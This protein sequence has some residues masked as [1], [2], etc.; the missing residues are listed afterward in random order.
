[1]ESF[2]WDPEKRWANLRKH[3]LDFADVT[4][5]F[6]TERYDYLSEQRGEESKAP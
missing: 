4:A 2:E 5:I 6:Q 1:M 3:G